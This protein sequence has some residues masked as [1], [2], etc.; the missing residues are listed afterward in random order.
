MRNDLLQVGIASKKISQ[1]AGTSGT[2]A[3]QFGRGWGPIGVGIAGIGRQPR[4][5][6]VCQPAGRVEAA[7]GVVARQRTT[8][9]VAEID[10]REVVAAGY[11][12]RE[13]R[14]EVERIG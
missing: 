7:I 5:D 8:H 13:L 6:F 12:T 9:L 11:I 3:G 1:A 14:G 10:L 4:K 2:S